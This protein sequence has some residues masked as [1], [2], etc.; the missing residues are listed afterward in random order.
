MFFACMRRKRKEPNS[1]IKAWSD[2][3]FTIRPSQELKL[4]GH[5]IDNIWH[6]ILVTNENREII[7]IN[8]SMASL[9][10]LS[11]EDVLGRKTINV[12]NN[13]HLEKFI[14]KVFESLEPRRENIIFYEDEELYMDMEAFLVTARGE[15]LD[16][17]K[18]GHAAGLKLVILAK[19]NTQEI[20]F[21]KLRSQFV[22]NVSHEMRTPITSIRGYLEIL[23]DELKED[24]KKRHFVSKSLEETERLNY[25]IEDVLNLSKIEYKRNV[26]LKEE[27]EIIH[28]IREIL[29]GL[30]YLARQNQIEIEFNYSDETINFVTDPDLFRQL[31]K[32]LAEN[33]IFH[34]GRQSRLSISVGSTDEGIYLYFRD[35]GV[36]ISKEDIPYIF[37][38]F[39]RGKTPFSAKRIGSGL[40]LSIVKHIV[41]LHNGRIRVQ[42]KPNIETVFKVFLP[43]KQ[44]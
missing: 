16:K 44:V 27:V 22:A 11:P 12:F 36:G 34:A 38:R 14:G 39:Y 21:S 42:S 7:S 25:L 35:D 20:E 9:F 23:E 3:Y 24:E 30:R 18:K 10:Y 5:I 19:N 8:K 6:G 40:G 37:Q 43:A 32:N 29:D 1:P 15:L 2:K 13:N 41:D 26:L 17:H 28:A 31:V 4:L 33:S